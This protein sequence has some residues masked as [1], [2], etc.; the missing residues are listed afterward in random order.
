M[1]RIVIEDDGWLDVDV[2][3]PGGEETKARIDVLHAYQMACMLKEKSPDDAAAQDRQWLEWL[4]AAG[5]PGL[6]VRAGGKV[7]EA[8]RARMG[9]L[10]PPTPTA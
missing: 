7:F 2:S 1:D 6:T 5:L 3:R 9:E 10:Y 4:A 8:I